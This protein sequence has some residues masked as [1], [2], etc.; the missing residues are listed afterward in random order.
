EVQHVQW[1]KKYSAQLAAQP[2][3]VGRSS[4]NGTTSTS[5][6]SPVQGICL[7]PAPR[8]RGKGG[9]GRGGGISCAVDGKVRASQS[10]ALPPTVLV[11]SENGCLQAY[12][13]VLGAELAPAA[14]SEAASATAAALQGQPRSASAT[15]ATAAVG[16]SGSSGGAGGAA[17]CSGN[18]RLATGA[19]GS[20]SMTAPL[21]SRPALSSRRPPPT[22]RAS[23]VA[24]EEGQVPAAAGGSGSGGAA[25]PAA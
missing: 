8:G 16:G 17:D 14:E 6:G 10:A 20:G 23:A 7:C 11:L 1:P 15:S 3:S 22:W 19:S 21:F 4:L 12:S 24:V 5:S 13:L 25:A 9:D 18:P 2:S